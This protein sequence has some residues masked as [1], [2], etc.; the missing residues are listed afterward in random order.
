MLK[1]GL[2]T[3]KSKINVLLYVSKSLCVLMQYDT[4]NEAYEQ[5]V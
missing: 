2:E 5:T 3:T 1:I 4:I